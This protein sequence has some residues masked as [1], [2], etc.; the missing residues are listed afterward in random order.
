MISKVMG[1]DAAAGKWLAVLLVDGAFVGADLQPSLAALLE[2]HPDVGVV[3]IDIPIGLPVG[4]TRPADDAART[5]VGPARASSVFETFPREVLEAPSYETAVELARRLV[6]RA[7]SQQ[8]YALRKYILEVAP[9]AESD[10][11]IVEV[12]PEVSF[13]AMQGTPLRYSKRSWSGIAERR[14]LLAAMGI[15]LPEDLPDGGRVAPDDVVDAAAAAWSALRIATGHS[16]TLPSPPPQDAA[17]G[18]VIHY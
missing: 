14:A 8:A 15:R 16:G 1:V 3:A 4:G 13:R 17:L 7:P 6:S 9:A 2:R 11:R 10:Q 12:H 18:G 5:F